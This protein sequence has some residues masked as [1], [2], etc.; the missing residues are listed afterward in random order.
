[1]I[2]FNKKGKAYR[3]E[4]KRVKRKWSKEDADVLITT[5]IPTINDDDLNKKP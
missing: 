3:A 4:K 1:M 2:Y 5:I